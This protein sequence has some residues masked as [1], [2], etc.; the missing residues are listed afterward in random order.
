M[1]K[2]VLCVVFAFT[3]TACSSSEPAKEAA[4]P[5]P[6]PK[7]AAAELWNVGIGIETPESAYVD[8][9]SGDIYVSII[10]GMPGE[11]DGNGRIAKISA[12]GRTTNAM[13]AEGMNAPKGLRS[14]EGTLWTADIDQ[15]LGFD[16]ATGKQTSKVTVK[17]A[18]FLNDVAVGADGTVYVSD[19]MGN[20]IYALKGGKLSV[21]A[22]GEELLEHPNGLLVEGESLVVGGWGSKP[23]DDFTTDVKGRLFRIDLKTKMKTLITPEPTA[24][25]DGLESDGSGGYILSDYLA[26]TI[27]H[28]SADGK[29]KTLTTF[30]PSTADI[31]YSPAQKRLFIPHMNQ[32]KITAYDISGALQ[33]KNFSRGLR[34][35]RGFE[36]AQ[37]A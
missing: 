14:H 27:L 1:F 30:M 7:P 22:E 17:G 23:K 29:V 34:G 32:N 20:K 11:K 21:A 18:G 25:I 19:M 9:A 24:N 5:P 31:G 10:A 36:S 15:I 3:L 6:P 37:S 26:G 28:V 12:D 33:K 13:W 16:M 35:L 8:P 4:P 2:R